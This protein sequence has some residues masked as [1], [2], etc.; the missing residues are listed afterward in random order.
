MSADWAAGAQCDQLLS[1]EAFVFLCTCIF[2]KVGLRLDNLLTRKIYCL[3]L[4]FIVS[5]NL[6]VLKSFQDLLS[7]LKV[8]IA[9]SSVF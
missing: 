7:Y 5:K 1:E 4:D 9:T 3:F 8:Q 6:T 2:T